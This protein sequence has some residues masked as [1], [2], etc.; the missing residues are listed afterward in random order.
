MNDHYQALID[1]AATPSEAP[2]LAAAA[3][4]CLSTLEVV[5]TEL[6]K[7][8][9]LGE[10]GYPAGPGCRK[11]Y[12]PDSGEDPFWNRS[13]SGVEALGN[14]W[15]NMFGL[16]QFEQAE[17]PV[18]GHRHGTEFIGQIIGSVERFVKNMDVPLGRC[19][20]CGEERSLH[21][22]RCAPHP[23]FVHLSIIF[24]NWPSFDALGWRESV[25]ELL[26]QTL[27]RPLLVTHGQV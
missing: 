3:V 6:S 7:R 9:V 23:G 12:V 19:A 24:W 21:E 27:D 5:E 17:C 10:V 14:P 13:I 15:V 26:Q 11:M 18:C 1:V 2:D 16:T 8:C 20:A 4:R 22:W 25:P